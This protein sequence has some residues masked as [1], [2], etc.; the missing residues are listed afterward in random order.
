NL[1]EKLAYNAIRKMESK[2]SHYPFYFPISNVHEGIKDASLI[3]SSN[4]QFGEGWRIP[5]E[6]S[7]FAHNGINN[8]ISLQPFG[9]I[10][11]HI[12]SKGIEKRTK[13]LFPN[14]NL[15]F[16]DFDSGMSEAN[17]YNRLHFMIRN[18]QVEVSSVNKHEL[19]DAI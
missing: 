1:V 11:N 18:A 5:A 2:I 14:M 10:A 4:A 8:V 3:I 16:L 7:E 19:V 6:F 15:L 9:C 13:E 12:I 17:I